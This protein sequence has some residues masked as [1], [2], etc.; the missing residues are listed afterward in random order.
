LKVPA[1]LYR[2]L[3]A[4]ALDLL[5]ELAARVRSISG[6]RAPLTVTST[7]ADAR[8]EQLLGFDDPPALTGYTFQIARHYASH[9]QAEA[10]QAMLDRLQSMNLIAWIR[11]TSTIEITVAADADKV[12]TAGP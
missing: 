1:A 8:Y 12:I 5:I 6:A 4:P 10:F 3:R 11:G 2:G 9:A 7:V